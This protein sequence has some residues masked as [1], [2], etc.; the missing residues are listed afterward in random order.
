M[1]E[2]FEEGA[3]EDKTSKYNSAIDQLKRMGNIWQMATNDV[4]TGNLR[5]WNIALDRIW[6]ELA[7]DLEEEDKREDKFNNLNKEIE[8]LSPL[9][10][11]NAPTFNKSEQ[12]SPTTVAKQYQAI[13][14]KELF[15]RRLQ[16][17]LGKGTAFSDGDDD[18]F[19]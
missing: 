2:G 19:E 8:K 5:N 1:V 18:D 6:A 7:G 11:G 13:L 3:T 16:N 9:K 12:M 10:S 14:K 17:E 15:L 4:R